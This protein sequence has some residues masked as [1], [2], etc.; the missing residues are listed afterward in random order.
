MEDRMN[1]DVGARIVE[2]LVVIKKLL[3]LNLQQANGWSQRTLA[4]K[5]GVDQSTLS[6]LF[7]GRRQS[8]RGRG[9][10]AAEVADGS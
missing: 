7:T 9:K 10:Q 1:N 5:L 4:T 8:R 2:E 6:R 3:M